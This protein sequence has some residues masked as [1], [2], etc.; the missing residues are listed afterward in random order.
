MTLE[1]FKKIMEKEHKSLDREGMY[2][3]YYQLLEKEIINNNFDLKKDLVWDSSKVKGQVNEYQINKK[4]YN[5]FWQDF[6]QQAPF[7][8]EIVKKAF[9]KTGIQRVT[10]RKYIDIILNHM[11]P[12]NKEIQKLIIAVQKKAIRQIEGI[13]AVLENNKIV[14]I[15]ITE[16][17]FE[18]EEKKI[19]DGIKQHSNELPLYQLIDPNNS[20]KFKR[21]IET[22]SLIEVT[23]RDLEA[24]LYGLIVVF[25]PAYNFVGRTRPF[26]FTV[27]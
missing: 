18:N 16:T 27:N 1:E 23:K 15:G 10:I 13:Y 6:E 2:K 17:S 21:L 14:Y 20:I 7:I 5:N 4:N 11:I 24:M 22:N 26:E 12:V 8:E 25:K 3:I 9:Y 19:L